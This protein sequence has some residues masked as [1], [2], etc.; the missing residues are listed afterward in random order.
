MRT[1]G[2]LPKGSP[3]PFCKP[4]LKLFEWA[5]NDDTGIQGWLP[6]HAPDNFDPGEGVLIAHDCL[7]H[8]FKNDKGEAHFEFM[9]LGQALVVRAYYGYI[10]HQET[11]NTPHQNLAYEWGRLIEI[12]GDRYEPLPEPPPW[13][14]F[15]GRYEC[16]VAETVYLA[17]KV[18]KGEWRDLGCCPPDKRKEFLRKAEGWFRHGV[19]LG[20]RK[21]RRCHFPLPLFQKIELESTRLARD[22]V[23]GDYLGVDLVIARETVRL[24]RF[25]SWDD[26]RLLTT[27]EIRRHMLEHA[28]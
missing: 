28:Y 18:S 11:F 27:R 20:Q 23:F 6:L 26:P 9:A 10:R 22:A 15:R 19:R 5:E 25:P 1:A 16:D 8:T 13:R 21:Y 17:R 24:Y 12:A 4:L 2:E 3:A 14:A 7:E